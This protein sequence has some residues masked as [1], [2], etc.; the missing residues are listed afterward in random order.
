MMGKWLDIFR[1]GRKR[2]D[3]DA[4]VLFVLDCL[5][6]R[7]GDGLFEASDEELVI[8]IGEQRFGLQSLRAVYDRDLLSPDDLRKRTIT[9]FD[10]MLAE[11]D[12]E[13][14][15]APP[16]WADA[17]ARL[18]PQLMPTEYLQQAPATLL[19]FP[20]TDDVAIGVVVDR[21]NT[22]A[23]VREE[24]PALWGV[25]SAEVYEIAVQNLDRASKEIPMHA[26]PGADRFVAIEA[27]DGYD[28]A[29]I[30][31]PALRASIAERL[32]SPFLA[33]IPNRDFLICWAQGASPEFDAFVREK[34]RR[35][36][37]VQPYP[38]TAEVLLA[39]FETIGPESAA[40][41]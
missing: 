1:R 19:S 24:D 30:L 15:P 31:V 20:L 14:G 27:G 16:L 39:T 10:R 38:L 32:G 35:G 18:R 4:F 17:Q 3:D 23:Y 25:T 41:L 37:A 40:L 2:L 5:T 28:A 7:Y 9:H 22:Y 13:R 11:V 8:A 33:A 26:G 29:R 21:E 6:E 34:V 12:E 36:N